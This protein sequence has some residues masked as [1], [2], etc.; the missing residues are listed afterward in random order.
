MPSEP[1]VT[2]AH[3]LRPYRY[4]K[5]LAGRIAFIRLQR[6]LAIHTIKTIPPI[7]ARK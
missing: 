4:G 1:P 6:S 5:F 3:V 2:T 7:T